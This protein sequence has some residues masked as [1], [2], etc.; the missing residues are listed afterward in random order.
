LIFGVLLHHQITF[1]NHK[2]MENQTTRKVITKGGHEAVIINNETSIVKKENQFFVYPNVTNGKEAENQD[3]T[4]FLEAYENWKADKAAEAAKKI[5]DTKQAE[6]N[7]IASIKQRILTCETPEELAQE[8]DLSL[9]ETAGHWNQ[10]YTGESR[11][12]VCIGSKEEAEIMEIAK[13]LLDI[14]GEFGEAKNRAGEHH[15]TFSSCYD[16]K[17]FQENCKRRF[18]G[19]KYFYKS[20]ETESD[21]ILREIKESAQTIDDVKDLLKALDKIEDGYYDC[22]GGLVILESELE[23]AD[24]TGYSEDVYTYSFCFRFEHN[25]KFNDKETELEVNEI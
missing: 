19:N 20:E 9:I 7:R 13:D 16:L 2:T 6:E 3:C 14:E 23:S 4:E 18:R 21:F 1:K 22:N 24:F 25:F 8:F 15:S 10:L 11:Y 5:A 17:D 12:A